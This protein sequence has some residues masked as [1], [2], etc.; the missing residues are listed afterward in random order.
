MDIVDDELNF[1][2]L[3]LNPNDTAPTLKS[4]DQVQQT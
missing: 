2:N 3:R 4:T 1:H